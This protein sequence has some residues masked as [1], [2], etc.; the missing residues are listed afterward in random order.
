M[1]PLDTWRDAIERILS[2]HAAIPYANSSAKSEVVFDRNRDH[3]LIVDT[4]WDHGDRVHF[5][6]VHIDIHDGR[7]W[8][9]YDG[10]ERGIA[11]ELVE[12]GVPREGIVLGFREPE[13]RKY[14]GYAAA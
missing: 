2:D 7:V 8:I 12:A 10:T 14:T 4:G 1:D 5:T 11:T 9:E 3:Y 13:L 6:L